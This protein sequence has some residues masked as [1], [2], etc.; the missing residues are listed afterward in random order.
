MKQT[1]V[2]S[3]HC[4][5]CG[6]NLELCVSCCH[7]VPKF[8]DILLNIMKINKTCVKCDQSVDYLKKKPIDD[9]IVSIKNDGTILK[10]GE[11][12]KD[13]ELNNIKDINVTKMYENNKGC[14]IVCQK[15]QTFLDD[16]K[17]V[18]ELSDNPQEIIN[19]KKILNDLYI[20]QYNRLLDFFKYK[21]NLLFLTA[22]FNINDKKIF[23]TS[24]IIVKNNIGVTVPVYIYIDFN[25][26][27]NS[28]NTRIIS[29]GRLGI[30]SKI[31]LYN[32]IEY[33]QKKDNRN[34]DMY[35][36]YPAFFESDGYCHSFVFFS[37][38]FIF[39]NNIKLENKYVFSGHVTSN[40]IIAPS[41]KIN[42]KIFDAIKNNVKYFICSRA[43]QNEINHQF[44]NKINIK[45]I[46][47]AD[48]LEHILSECMKMDVNNTSNSININNSHDIKER[49]K[50]KQST[51]FVDIE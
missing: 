39:K 3:E 45:F 41:A 12:I 29:S 1:F 10:N 14:V 51:T 34:F 40:G 28:Q 43:N 4:E 16:K 32:V 48:D 20:K 17:F 6:N 26:A 30:E 5:N 19:Q 46:N 13:T 33:I 15:I 31:S 25:P 9:R 27:N 18:F 7:E 21:A 8:S 42:S 47:T 24:S 36:E 49:N 50:P 37:A 35:I 23:Y 11:K 44:Y 2:P 22:K 38:Y